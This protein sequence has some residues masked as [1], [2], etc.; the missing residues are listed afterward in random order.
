MHFSI[1]NATIHLVFHFLWSRFANWSHART[2]QR[3]CAITTLF[4]EII[5]MVLQSANES[6]L[7]EAFWGKFIYLVVK[8]DTFQINFCFR[9]CKRWLPSQMKAGETVIDLILKFFVLFGQDN[10]MY[11]CVF[12]A[13]CICHNIRN[14][15]D[16][17]P[18]DLWWMFIQLLL[19][20]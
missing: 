11:Y 2:L 1:S 7:R 6:E 13:L 8:M 4:W 10:R 12:W 20:T 19:K 18:L 15:N 16:T 3:L 9:F 5:M 17:V 14:Q